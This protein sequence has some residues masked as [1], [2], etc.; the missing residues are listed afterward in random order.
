MPSHRAFGTKVESGACHFLAQ[1]GLSLVT[2]NF[3][4]R[5]G[6]IDLIMLDVHILVFIEVRYRATNRFGGGKGSVTTP[7]QLRLIRTASH[8][9]QRKPQFSDCVCRFD[10]VAVT[11]SVKAFCYEWI[12]DAFRLE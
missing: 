12:Q 4:C 2:R 8:F 3:S 1:R 11:G 10:V 5:M 7:K 9:L 6:E